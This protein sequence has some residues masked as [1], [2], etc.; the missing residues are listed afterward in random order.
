VF[1]ELATFNANVPVRG[2][3]FYLVEENTFLIASLSNLNVLSSAVLGGERRRT[4]FIM[5]HTIGKDYSSSNPAEDLARLAEKMNLGKDVLGLMTAVDVRW[6]Q[7]MFSL[8]WLLFFASAGNMAGSMIAYTI[9]WYF[10]RPIVLR[11]GKYIGITSEKLD[12]LEGKFNKYGVW[13]VFFSKFIAGIRVLVPYLSGINRMPL[14][15]FA[16]FSFVSAIL[17]A[18][19][20][21]LLGRYIEITWH[22]YYQAAHQFL[23]PG[24]I[25]VAL[26]IGCYLFI[27]YR[28][29]RSKGA[30]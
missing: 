9:G 5:N 18:S 3:S 2:I 16:V 25:I 11:F 14:T 7:G 4:R 24:I 17:W 29:S 27:K 15:R 10:G 6:Q 20:F 23:L 13:I 26:I 21:V 28:N 8:P 22:H 12:K 1:K 30:V 19:V